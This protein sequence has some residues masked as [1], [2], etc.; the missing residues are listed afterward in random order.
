VVLSILK[1]RFLGLSHFSV[2]NIF[3]FAAVLIASTSGKKNH[4]FRSFPFLV[5][6]SIN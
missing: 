4:M 5:V 2:C 6:F 1:P 3:A